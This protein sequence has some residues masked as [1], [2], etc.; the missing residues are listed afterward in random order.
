MT[1]LPLRILIGALTVLFAALPSAC[2]SDRSRP[3]PPGQT[4]PVGDTAGWHQVFADDFKTP[5]DMGRFSGCQAGP[6]L[7]KS[8]CG[9]LPAPVRAKWWVYPDGWRDTG[10]GTYYPSQVLSINHGNLDYAIHTTSINGKQTHLIAASVPKISG[11]GV[12]GGR[13]YGRFVIRFRASA[14]PGYH[15][16]FLLWPDSNKWPQ[17]GEIDFPEGNLDGHVLAFMHHQGAVRPDQQDVYRTNATFTSWHT[18]AIDWRRKYCRFI[19]D[20][21]VVGVSTAHIPDTPMH[22][23][24]QV[25]ALGGGLPGHEPAPGTGGHVQVAWVAAYRAR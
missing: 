20:G 9:G 19:L 22:W 8:N 3:D 25:N 24:L 11:A 7:A 13:V 12:N 5:V 2:A 1:V 6:T 18:A 21:K 15:L 23:V 17:D 16:A 14:L 4:M 10:T